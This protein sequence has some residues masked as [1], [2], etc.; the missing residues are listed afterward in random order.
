RLAAG[1]YQPEPAEFS[2]HVMLI[3]LAHRYHG[4]LEG[5]AA[6]VRQDA[7]KLKRIVDRLV[8]HAAQ[9]GRPRI[10]VVASRP[11]RLRI[12]PCDEV[13]FDPLAAPSPL[14]PAVARELTRLLGG[15]V[16]YGQDYFE[17]ELPDL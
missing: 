15:E 1:R 16:T 13:S 4:V 3:E 7:T 10:I 9:R 2:P 5:E 17:V 6:L 11:L 12:G 14:G 8:H